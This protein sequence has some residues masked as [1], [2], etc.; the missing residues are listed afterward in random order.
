MI[1]MKMKATGMSALCLLAVSCD[2]PRQ[3]PAD[4]SD[5]AGIIKALDDLKTPIDEKLLTEYYPEAVEGDFLVNFN[6]TGMDDTSLLKKGY[7]ASLVGDK[8]KPVANIFL[9]PTI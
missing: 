8:E 7:R 4:A 5:M 6:G 1:P 3:K 2:H 9:Q